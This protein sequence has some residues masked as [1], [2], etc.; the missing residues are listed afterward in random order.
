MSDNVRAEV[1][2][3]IGSAFL[4]GEDTGQIEDD[5]SLKEAGIITSVGLMQLVSHLETTYGIELSAH[6]VAAG[7]DTLND[8]VTLIREKRSSK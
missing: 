3:Y 7:L 6:E 5:M 2:S 8:I 4:D 1:L